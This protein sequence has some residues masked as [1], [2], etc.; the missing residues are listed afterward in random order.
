MLL[1]AHRARRVPVFDE[2]LRVSEVG[3]QVAEA[4]R[5][6]LWPLGVVV[7]AFI[8]PY[9]WIW[10]FGI[11][12][13]WSYHVRIV[14]ARGRALETTLAAETTQLREHVHQS[15]DRVQ[16][17][18]VHANEGAFASLDF[19]LKRWLDRRP[20]RIKD[21][22]AQISG[23]FADGWL[24]VGDAI[25]CD[26]IPDTVARTGRSG[27][28]VYDKRRATEIDED[29][30]ELNALAALS[31]LSALFSSPTRQCVT[32]CISLVKGSTEPVPWVTFSGWMSEKELA[33]VT[34]GGDG[35]IGAPSVCIRALGGD[36]GRCRMQRLTP[37]G[38]AVVGGPESAGHGTQPERIAEQAPAAMFESSARHATVNA[39]P[40]Y[41]TGG[42]AV[43]FGDPHDPGQV[44]QPVPPI[45]GRGLGPRPNVGA[46]GMSPTP[47]SVR[48]EFS[49]TARR[50]VAYTGAPAAQFVQFATYWPTYESMS[51]AQLEFYFWWRDTARHGGTPRTDLSYIFV[52]I[53]ELL[54]IIGADSPHAAAIQI[55]AV[56][57]RYRAAFPKLD[58]YCV[59]W[60]A[61][62]YAKA[63]DP[64]SAR[65]FIRRVVACGCPLGPDETLL[66]MDDYWAAGNYAEMPLAGIA[67]LTNDQR[68][69]ENKFFLKFNQDGWVEAAYR[70]A[71]KV[72]DATY[73]DKFGF[74]LR[75]ST[76][77]SD[78]VRLVVRD[79]FTSAVYDWKRQP[80]ILGTVPRLSETSPSVQV[81]RNAVRYTENILR[82]E[83]QFS[84]K[85][86]G[87]DA[88]PLL[89]A[90]LNR[91]FVGHLKATHPRTA[92][93]I[94]LSRAR[95]LA[96]ESEEVRARLLLGI[97]D[98]TE[99]SLA[100]AN[101]TALST[102]DTRPEHSPEPIPDGL[103]T[104]LDAIRKTIDC[105]SDPARR[106]LGALASIGWEGDIE[107][108]MLVAATGGALVTPLINEINH[109][110]LLNVGDVLIVR[111]DGKLV[112][113]E[114]FRDELY[115]ILHGTLS[116][117]SRGPHVSIEKTQAP[118]SEAAPSPANITDIEGFG[119]VAFQA[120]RIISLGGP[121]LTRSLSEIASKNATTPLLI[122]E[123]VN[124]AG[125][126]CAYGDL[127]VDDATAPP[128][129][130][131]DAIPYVSGL[132]RAFDDT[133]SDDDGKSATMSS[134]GISLTA[135]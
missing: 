82:A 104:D 15:A 78:G 6:A 52:N 100:T 29:L 22:T 81:F 88:G 90:A 70:D 19:L 38:R 105:V 80:V 135:K 50:F 30:S 106:I 94:D 28:A 120:L 76:I 41:S 32:L 20:Q 56:W 66:L 16:A 24:I 18:L 43:A 113:H 17:A 86:R 98:G 124:E 11:L 55:E 102:G 122:I 93:K 71:L 75:E 110:A 25:R 53:Y 27:R 108:T 36:V 48:G 5:F 118:K 131:S 9:A 89:T 129:I 87:V 97:G 114:D 34:S 109:Q 68:V 10:I 13:A 54:H 126:A 83:K 60:I 128:S 14:L 58:G 23:S 133:P 103:L 84:A 4:K 35:L 61:D 117:F 107:A 73:R 1:A 95:D 49:V 72:A 39:A 45:P 57:Q 37:A 74:T 59:R 132:V 119:S 96:R 42:V 127:L 101:A 115:W 2:Q 79:P 63:S 92:I 69:G 21:F 51:T 65:E 7:V 99:T 31:L 125:L 47:S 130:M 64:A 3:R 134:D 46:T 121:S 8:L 67:T 91:H 62:L 12:L 26:S 44:A 77:T 40:T 123:R 116:G 33:S 111:E 85:L 112:V